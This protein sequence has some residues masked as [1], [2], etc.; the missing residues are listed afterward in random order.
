L[1][2]PRGHSYERVRG[3]WLS[4]AHVFRV[5]VAR[6][7]PVTQESRSNHTVLPP[8][9]PW[10]HPR[11]SATGLRQHQSPAALHVVRHAPGTHG[12]A[13]GTGLISPGGAGDAR[14]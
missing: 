6:R 5:L 1:L 3:T 9:G 14:P 13:Y 7:L 2:L 12:L 4:T 11:S 8:P 10:H